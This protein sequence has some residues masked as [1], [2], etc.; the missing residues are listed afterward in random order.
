MSA[1]APLQGPS[2]G[3]P[4]SGW[5]GWGGKF[6]SKASG[7]HVRDGYVP[8]AQPVILSVEPCCVGII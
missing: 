6:G 5:G 7:V 1:P 8:R 3:D 2:L 4:T